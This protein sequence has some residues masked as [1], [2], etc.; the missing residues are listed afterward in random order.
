MPSRFD[1]RPR[2]NVCDALQPVVYYK[3]NARNENDMIRRAYSVRGMQLNVRT[4]LQV[5][6]IPPSLPVN[7][8]TELTGVVRLLR[9]RD[10]KCGLPECTVAV[11]VGRCDRIAEGRRD[12]ASS[13][14]AVESINCHAK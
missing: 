14:L 2:I 4:C 5:W 1:S 3:L 6:P 8:K 12:A 11:V 10:R 9:P 7:A 13:Y